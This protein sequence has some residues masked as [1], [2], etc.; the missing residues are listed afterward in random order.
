MNSKNP[1]MFSEWKDK[2]ESRVF[3]D[4]ELDVFVTIILVAM[5]TGRL[6]LKGTGYDL[7]AVEVYYLQHGIRS[8]DKLLDRLDLEP[9]FLKELQEMELGRSGPFEVYTAT[10]VTTLPFLFDMETLSVPHNGAKSTPR[11]LAAGW[12]HEV[13]ANRRGEGYCSTTTTSK[14]RRLQVDDFDRVVKQRLLNFIY[15]LEEK[16]LTSA[17]SYILGE[18]RRLAKTSNTI[19]SIQLSLTE[20]F[21]KY[22]SLD[23]LKRIF[24]YEFNYA[25]SENDCLRILSVADFVSVFLAHADLDI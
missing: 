17:A 19:V 24:A 25:P 5:N 21:A 15:R 3:L 11:S 4:V 20:D 6:K 16:K 8:A 7:D 2:L 13:S 9:G 14:R 22:Y 10:Y 12:P 23:S 1:R 18:I